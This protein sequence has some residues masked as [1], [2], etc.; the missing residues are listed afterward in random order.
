[1]VTLLDIVQQFSN[2]SSCIHINIGKHEALGRVGG[3]GDAEGGGGVCMSQAGSLGVVFSIWGQSTALPMC[4]VT[5]PWCLAL[6]NID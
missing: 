6:R 4:G 3:Y 1:M 5:C 2:P